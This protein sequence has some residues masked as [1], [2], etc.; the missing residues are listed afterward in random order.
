M[1]AT[2]TEEKL[3]TIW[4]WLQYSTLFTLPL[5][6]LSFI[7]AIVR[8]RVIPISLILRR[9]A[10][11]LLVLRGAILLEVVAASLF[12]AALL[13]W[14]SA[15]FH[16]SPV[17]IAAISGV[18]SVLAWQCAN[19]LRRRYLAPA[20]DRQF[21]RQAYDAQQILAELAESL[22]TT[23]DIPR[24]LEAVANKLQSALQTESAIIFLRDEKTGDYCSAYGCVYSPADGRAIK[25]NGNHHLPRR[26]ATVAQL[27]QTGAPLELDGGHPAFD[28]AAVNGHSRL[29][30]E[31]RQM[32]LA[33]Q[34]A[35]LL[36]LKTQDALLGVVA[37]GPRLGDLPFSG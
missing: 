32:L 11:N 2:K 22:H 16:L 33:S 29:T 24:L 15:R 31:E 27:A 3:E 18:S 30:A 19:Y 34:V 8:H 6:P 14:L 35:L 21:F 10:R 37:L 9:G 26:A 1:E 17:L 5:V 4:H 7:Y 23:N 13:T 36:P 12:V 20:I 25:R 28:L